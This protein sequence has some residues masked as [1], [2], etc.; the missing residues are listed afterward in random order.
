VTASRRHFQFGNSIE[1]GPI[2]QIH[3]AARAGSASM[4]FAA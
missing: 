1:A 2:L 3:V 4:P